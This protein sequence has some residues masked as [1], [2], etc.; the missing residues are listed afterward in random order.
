MD[1]DALIARRNEPLPLGHEFTGDV[2]DPQFGRNVTAILA[3]SVGVAI[4]GFC[5]DLASHTTAIADYNMRTNYSWDMAAPHDGGDYC[6]PPPVPNRADFD[7]PAG[8]TLEAPD[9]RL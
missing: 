9:L 5:V 8:K 7:D 6:T 2:S 3:F 1:R 4:G